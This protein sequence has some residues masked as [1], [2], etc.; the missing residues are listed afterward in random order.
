MNN[1]IENLFNKDYTLVHDNTLKYGITCLIIG[2]IIVIL[3]FLINKE[4]FYSNTISFIDKNRAY[5]IVK[6]DKMSNITNNKTIML[7]NINYE[8]DVIKVEEKE[9]LFLV[10]IIFKINELNIN[11]NKY[12]IKLSDESI[13]NYI[14]RIMKGE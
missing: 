13:M 10:E 9:D 12:S 3:L 11:T 8:Y 5:L 6:K 14:L 1:R 4:C 2:I 7:N